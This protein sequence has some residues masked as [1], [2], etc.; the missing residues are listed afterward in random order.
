MSELQSQRAI[1][2]VLW[3]RVTT[4]SESGR[5]SCDDVSLNLLYLVP[6]SDIRY[7]GRAGGSHDH[8]HEMDT[9]HVIVLVYR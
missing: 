9:H 3:K 4:E 1:Y 7:C 6:I 8:V 5:N 2:F